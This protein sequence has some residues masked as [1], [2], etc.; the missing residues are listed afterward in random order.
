MSPKKP[1]ITKAAQE[2]KVSPKR[3]KMGPKRPQKPLRALPRS[4]LNFLRP[5]SAHCSRSCS[6]ACCV[7]VLV[8][9]VVVVVVGVAVVLVGCWLFVAASWSSCC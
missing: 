4:V 5:P 7:V 2:A 6:C 3:L 8:L 9:V 1:N